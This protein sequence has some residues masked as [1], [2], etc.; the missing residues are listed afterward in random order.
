MGSTATL[1]GGTRA[2]PGQNG[3]RPK[4]RRKSEG[5]VYALNWDRLAPYGRARE[6]GQIIRV[7]TD[8]NGGLVEFVESSTGEYVWSEPRGDWRKIR[9]AAP[10]NPPIANGNL[11]RVARRYGR[12]VRILAYLHKHQ[13]GGS[14]ARCAA[15]AHVADTSVKHTALLLYRLRDAGY[16]RCHYGR[17]A[18]T[19]LTGGSR[20]IAYW[21][22][23]D[24]WHEHLPR[25]V[26]RLI[27]TKPMS[28][29]HAAGLL[30]IDYGLVVKALADLHADGK[31]DR[32][33]RGP[34]YVYMEH[35]DLEIGGW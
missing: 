15:L 27:I 9:A 30:G 32:E 3:D 34:G 35:A 33:R 4:P 31:L 26:T 23:T 12:E 1:A 8:G 6:N 19:G 29:T 2:Y 13:Q 16:V 25:I 7:E 5:E 17:E 18:N 10:K 21:Q 20:K 28:A 14:G 24:S 22:T 11:K